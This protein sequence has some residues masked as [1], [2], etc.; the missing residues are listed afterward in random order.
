M[1]ATALF[2]EI[3]ITGLEAAIW[4]GFL[5]GCIFGEQWGGVLAGPFQVAGYLPPLPCWHWCTCLVSSRGR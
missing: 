2:A 4:L 5:I 3:V 1:N